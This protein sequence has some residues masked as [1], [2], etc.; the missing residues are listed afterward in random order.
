VIRAGWLKVST[1][2]VEFHPAAILLPVGA[3][4]LTVFAMAA[5]TLG[6]PERLTGAV[7]RITNV[8]TRAGYSP[9]G[10]VRLGDGSLVTI[11][12]DDSLSCKVGDR[13]RLRRERRILGRAYAA[14]LNGCTAR[15]PQPV[16]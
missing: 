2:W 14:E 16:R 10:A 6:P 15:P 1:L 5:V 3:L 13:I 8:A 4:V 7:E 9:L 12:L 11:R